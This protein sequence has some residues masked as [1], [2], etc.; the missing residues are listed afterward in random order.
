MKTIGIYNNST[1]PAEP[2]ATTGQWGTSTKNTEL[3]E[4]EK[5]VKGDIYEAIRHLPHIGDVATVDKIYEIFIQAIRDAQKYTAQEAYLEC[6]A[7]ECGEGEC[8]E[9]VKSKF[10]L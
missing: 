2:I 5:Q 9:A 3:T 10:K 4:Q 6:L 8:S 7:V 1:K